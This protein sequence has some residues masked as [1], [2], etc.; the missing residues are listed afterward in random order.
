M[1]KSII[2]SFLLLFS[3]IISAQIKHGIR[4]QNGRHVIPRGFV[5][6]TNDH[7]GEIFF[8]AD[9]YVRMVQ[10]GANSQ[11][12]RLEISKLSTFPG[13]TP[14]QAYLEK[15][16]SLVDKGYH[17]GIN[18]VFKM[19][20]YGLSD[21]SWEQFWLNENNEHQTYIDAWKIIW[22][23]YKDND[24][25]W[26]YDLVNEP[27]K[28]SMEISYEGLTND[29]LIPLYQQMIDEHNKYNSQK[30]CLIQTIFMNKGD[31]INGN[32]YAEITA[33]L[34]RENIVFA[35]HIYQN[36]KELVLPTMLRFEKESDMLNA[37]IFLGEW[38]FPTFQTTDSAT[39][40]PLGQLTYIDFYQRTAEVFDSL[41]VGAIKPWFLGNRT[42][43]NFLP[44]GK[45][46]WSVFSDEKGVGTAERK[47]ITDIIARP[48]PQSVAGDILSFK[49]DFA[50]RSFD[51][52][53]NTDNNKGASRIFVGA[54]RHYP[55][56]FTVIMNDQFVISYNPLKNTGL[57]LFQSD[58][59][60][61]LSDFIW[62]ES[63]QQLIVLKWPQDKSNLHL[64][65]VPG[66]NN[67][68]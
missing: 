25:V 13:A 18:T 61:N 17:S 5:V 29:Y 9:D 39:T 67:H 16:D 54:N 42:Y 20:V 11:V 21:F 6:N 58:G 38:G 4:D 65:I 2:L 48:Y 40:G 3:G 59:N 50:T 19:T 14:G 23:R 55:D 8:T 44:G 49:F 60:G 43:Q 26:G 24:A 28:L 30:M 46:T 53:I 62:D 33:P 10:M 27:R 56:G 66:V 1:K 45:S 31:A 57:E 15:L 32:Q 63:R 64:K 22:E 34:N 68:Q 47:Y 36:K 37:P 7:V 51:M 52:N 12:I 41:G 35:P